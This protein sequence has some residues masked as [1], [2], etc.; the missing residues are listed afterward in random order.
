[1]IAAGTTLLSSLL[2]EHGHDSDMLVTALDARIPE[3]GEPN[4]IV[5][6]PEGIHT[7]RPTVDGKAKTITV[8]MKP[9]EGER[10]AASFQ[11]QLEKIQAGN[12]RPFMDFDHQEGPASGLP[13]RF[14]YEKGKGLMLEVEWTGRGRQAIE[15]K[16][17]SYFSPT[18]GGR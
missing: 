4:A 7:I 2:I 10:I 12:V 6:I 3:S 15:G 5:Y 17:Y 9:E 16:D 13:K 8:K 1:M 14:F 18:G 11:S